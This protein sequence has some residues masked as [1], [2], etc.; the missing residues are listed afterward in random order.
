MIFGMSRRLAIELAETPN[1]IK[2]DRRLAE[3][4]VVRIHRPRAGQ[5]QHGPE[6]H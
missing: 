5:I 2:R 3:A 1:V 6:Q 4:L